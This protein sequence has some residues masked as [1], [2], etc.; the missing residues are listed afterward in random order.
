MSDLQE[1]QFTVTIVTNKQTGRIQSETWKLD[2]EY[3]RNDGPAVQY[4]D[5]VTGR[6]L[7]ISFVRHGQLHRT[8]GP[9]R[10]FWDE[11]TGAL[12]EELW[13]VD[14]LEHREGNLPSEWRRSPETGVIVRE[15]YRYRGKQ[16]RIDGPSQIFRGRNG[17]VTEEEWMQEGI[18]TRVE[19]DGPARWLMDRETGVVT[20]EQYWVHGQIHRSTGPAIIRRDANSGKIEL[21]E[22][23]NRGAKVDGPTLT[24]DY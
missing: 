22:Y 15:G 3:H 14:G 1:E 10:Q 9:A 11:A 7:V 18:L 23:Y 8:D 13:V 20:E 12:I 21:A 16:H 2:G 6:P 4:F 24:N 5:L 17:Q 19:S